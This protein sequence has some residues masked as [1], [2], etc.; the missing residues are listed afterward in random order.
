MLPSCKDVAVVVEIGSVVVVKDD[1][2]DDSCCGVI[3]V[4]PVAKNAVDDAVDIAD[5]EAA[6]AVAAVAVIDVAVVGNYCSGANWAHVDAVAVAAAFLAEW[7][8]D[9]VGEGGND[10]ADAS[11]VVNWTVADGGAVAVVVAVVA[12][13]VAVAVGDDADEDGG[14]AAAGKSACSSAVRVSLRLQ[15]ADHFYCCR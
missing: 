4:A 2:V 14:D 5:A 6:V 1:Y 7:S 12:V 3:S 11:A 13:A 10:T 8:G 9:V 15:P